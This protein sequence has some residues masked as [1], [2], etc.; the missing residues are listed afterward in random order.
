MVGTG[1]LEKE[2]QKLIEE[3]QLETN[4]QMVGF[5]KNPYVYM[6]Q[7]KIS[8]IPSKWEGFGL[9]ALEAMAFGCPVVAANVGGLK[10]IVAETFKTL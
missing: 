9:V 10:E 4:V 3:Y 8:I 7:S 2:C 1:S 6:L 5:Q